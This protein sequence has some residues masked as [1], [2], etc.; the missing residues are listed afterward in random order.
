MEV[1]LE[2]WGGI[3]GKILVPESK[4]DLC[5]QLVK[6]MYD[7]VGSRIITEIREGSGPVGFMKRGEN[8]DD[9]F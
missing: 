7:R 4:L 3:E 6:L 9:F 1:V 8:G 2:T 5:R